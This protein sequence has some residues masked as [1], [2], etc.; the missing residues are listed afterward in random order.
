MHG[1][2]ELELVVGDDFTGTLVLVGEDTVLQAD[3]GVGGADGWALGG[4]R[5]GDIVGSYLK[6]TGIVLI[7]TIGGLTWHGRSEDGEKGEGG[8]GFHLDGLLRY[9]VEEEE[10]E[11]RCEVELFVVRWGLEVLGYWSKGGK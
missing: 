10:E 2:V 7:A 9:E 1:V 6:G 4:N 5:V 11:D 3:D 8:E